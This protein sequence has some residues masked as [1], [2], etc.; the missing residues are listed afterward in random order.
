MCVVNAKVCQKQ[1][2]LHYDLEA[3][4]IGKPNAVG[5]ARILR[6]FKPRVILLSCSVVRQSAL[7]RQRL[8]FFFVHRFGSRFDCNFVMS[9]RLA[10]FNQIS[11]GARGGDRGGDDRRCSGCF[12]PRRD[13]R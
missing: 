2:E 4:F 9:K 1:H 10:K 6:T 8:V 7:E 5:A 13:H 12:S 3:S 11:G